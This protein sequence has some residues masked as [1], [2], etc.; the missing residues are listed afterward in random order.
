MALGFRFKYSKTE[1]LKILARRRFFRT[2]LVHL[3]QFAGSVT[4]GKYGKRPDGIV[5]VS[6]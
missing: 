2:V 4:Y 3:D 6:G 1:W 5:I